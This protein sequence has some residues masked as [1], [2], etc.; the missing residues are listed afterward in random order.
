MFLGHH[1]EDLALKLIVITDKDGLCLLMSLRSFTKL[2]K[3]K[4]NSILLWQG[5]R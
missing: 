5:E 3:N 4:S 1:E 2:D